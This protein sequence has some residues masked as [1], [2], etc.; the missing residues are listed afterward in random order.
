V[1]G[2][3][4]N[5]VLPVFIVAGFGFA[6]ERRYRI[7]VVP[8]NQIVL[9]LLMPCFI[10]NS[11]L[12]FDLRSEEPLRVGAF[13]VLLTLVMLAVAAAV[14]LAMRLD[15][16][17]ASALM[18]TAAFPNLGNYGLSV[19]LLAF[20]QEGVR[21][22]TIL[23]AFQM[24]FSLTL[25]VFIASSGHA[26]LRDSLVQVVRQPVLYAVAAALFFGLSGTPVPA[27][28][29]AAIG[30]AGQAAIPM[31]LLALGMQISGTGRIEEPRLTAVAVILRLVLGAVLGALLADA[32]GLIGVARSVMI[33]GAAM[34]TAVFT[35]L[36]ATR[37]GTRPR[38]VTD[39]VV[40]STLASIVTVTAVLAL[41]SGRIG[42]L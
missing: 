11:L 9:Y 5:V 16:R 15:R 10:F 19:V 23:L 35:T 36:T 25:A 2:I 13:I 34:P 33:V 40:W 6:M 8:I 29:N 24:L 4:V 22:G 28:A 21:Y 20:G 3:F 38:F 31:M 32:L 37:Y 26:S 17:T 12:A 30:L 41:L 7:P 18:L 42:L 39:V 1:L 27:F 14:A